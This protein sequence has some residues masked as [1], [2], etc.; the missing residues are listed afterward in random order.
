VT[1]KP[2]WK[3]KARSKPGRMGDRGESP[4]ELSRTDKGGGRGEGLWLDVN[5]V[6][7]RGSHGPTGG[8]KEGRDADKTY[9][10]GHFL[11]RKKKG[12]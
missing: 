6:S 3:P 7:N 11:D 10:L 12:G 8:G 4:G 5:L 1:G 9:G 2:N